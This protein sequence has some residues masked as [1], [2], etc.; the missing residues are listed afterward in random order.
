MKNS[1]LFIVPIVIALLL[2]VNRLF[3]QPPP[4]G[5][6]LGG[7]PW[8][9]WAGIGGFLALAG[10]AFALRDARR[11][12]RLLAAPVAPPPPDEVRELLTK[13]LLEKYDCGGPN[14]PHPVVIPERCIACQACVDACPQ[15]V[16]AMV[17]NVAV[18]VARD[19]CVEEMSCQAE[20]PVNPVAVVVVNT[21]KVVPPRFAP[22]RDGSYMTNVP[23][24][25]VVGDVAGSPMI[26][27][28]A[29]EG[30]KVIEYIVAG[31][32]ASTT[33][34]Q[35][36][37]DVAIVGIGPAGLSA[38][39]A[40][41]QH[42]LRYVAI[43][44]DRTLSKILDYPKKKYVFF[45][46]EGVLP[47]CA[48]PF[49]GAGARLERV[50]E[51][52]RGVMLSSGV[53]I[54]GGESCKAV[55]RGEDGEYFIVRTEQG[56]EREPRTYLARRVVLSLGRSGAPR[57]LPAKNADMKVMRD[58][59]KEERVL[60][61]LSDPESFRRKHVAVVGGGNSAVEAAIALVARRNEDQIEFRPPEEINE[62]SLLVRTDFNKDLKFANK[63]LI[64]RCIDEGK[65]KAY[66]GTVVKEVLADEVVLMDA[67]T[68]EVTG[69]MANDYVLAL[70][71][72]DFPADFLNSIGIEIPGW[73]AKKKDGGVRGAEVPPMKETAAR[74]EH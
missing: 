37:F 49:A 11:E 12:L 31:L 72:G 21:T 65:V 57:K 36:E 48:L 34:Q 23:G 61:K 67:R 64:Y 38:A 59:R 3:A 20:C 74:P 5:S 58:G 50:L 62:V 30:A 1:Q 2:A 29:K 18:V 7:L 46:P 9:G 24:C 47:H 68:K 27:T 51:S 25:Y 16:L 6:Y 52:W 45:K 39:M 43:E 19:Q 55:E 28:A 71:G 15:S 66:F 54:N 22:T 73:E 41:K 4:A 10:A 33:G 26:K 8:Y 44:R 69:T 40:A 32:D 13:E 14:Y 53:V 60:D 63:M 56:D 42:G 70:I 35:A 17:K